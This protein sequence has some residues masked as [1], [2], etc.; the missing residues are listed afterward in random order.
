MTL[1]MAPR[2]DSRNVSKF[3]QKY[4][5]EEQLSSL[6][7]NKLFTGITFLIVIMTMWLIYLTV[8][9]NQYKTLLSSLALHKMFPLVEAQGEDKVVCHDTWVS[10]VIT[11]VSLV[12]IIYYIYI[13]SVGPVPY[14]MATCLHNHIL[15]IFL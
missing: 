1:D 2:N 10:V 12:A 7:N 3:I 9:M 6:I 15:C 11:T 8:K 14:V 4:M 5:A 13:N